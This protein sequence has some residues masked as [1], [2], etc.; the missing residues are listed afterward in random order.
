[1]HPAPLQHLCIPAA[2]LQDAWLF[3]EGT[4]T[5]EEAG[6]KGQVLK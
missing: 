5:S 1:M 2:L 3:S 4:V 6:L